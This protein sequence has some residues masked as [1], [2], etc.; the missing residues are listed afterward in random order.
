MHP[1]EIHHIKAYVVFFLLSAFLI[2]ILMY[3]YIP[4][5]PKN[6]LKSSVLQDVPV[7]TT[8]SEQ[9]VQPTQNIWGSWDI[10]SSQVTDVD[11]SERRMRLVKILIRFQ[12]ELQTLENQRSPSLQWLDTASEEKITTLREKIV[13]VEKLITEIK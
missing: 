12:K 3:L 8:V 9:S 5:N 10:S 7:S 13:T 4:T 2:G 6:I 1:H 11:A